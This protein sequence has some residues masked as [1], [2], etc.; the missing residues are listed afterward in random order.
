MEVNGICLTQPANRLNVNIFVRPIE[1]FVDSPMAAQAG[2]ASHTHAPVT[3][4]P[5]FLTGESVIV[6]NKGFNYPQQLD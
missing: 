6:E 5:E 1:S 4:S 3:F 2:L